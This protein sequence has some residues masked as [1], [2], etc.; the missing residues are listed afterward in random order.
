MNTE[1]KP[2]SEKKIR[3]RQA[4]GIHYLVDQK[5]ISKIVDRSMQLVD[6][7]QPHIFLEI[8]PGRGALTHEQLKRL[9]EKKFPHSFQYI[10]VD[11]DYEVEAYW[12]KQS[13]P[14]FFKFVRADFLTLD[15]KIWQSPRTLMV[16]NLPYSV[17]SSIVLKLHEHRLGDPVGSPRLEHMMFMLQKEVTQRIS[18]SPNPSGKN[19]SHRLGL[20]LQNIWDAKMFLD[21][22]PSAFKP[23]PKVQSQVIELTQ[24]QVPLIAKTLDEEKTWESLLSL[25]FL[26]RRRM[27]RALLKADKRWNQA[28]ERFPELSTKRAEELSWDDWKKL[29]QVGLQL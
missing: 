21:V 1:L 26:R 7:L 4:L 19:K 14:E 25:C 16:S 24:K 17:G 2:T 22:P 23:R 6:E 27:L 28:L 3:K 29:F 18:N 9:G 15:P 13:T 11:T 10:A 8:G 5:I 20:F 12:S